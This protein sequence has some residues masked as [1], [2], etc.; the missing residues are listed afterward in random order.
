M[1]EATAAQNRRGSERGFAVHAQ[2]RLTHLFFWF[3]QVGEVDHVHYGIRH[4]PDGGRLDRSPQLALRQSFVECMHARQ[5]HPGLTQV[6]EKGP[7]KG[8]ADTILTY[9]EQMGLL[10]DV[11][12]K[13]GNNEAA[14]HITS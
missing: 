8:L 13:S 2:K 6:R 5:S 1:A 9:E 11:A 4:E 14:H 10:Q 12:R 3:G 7:K